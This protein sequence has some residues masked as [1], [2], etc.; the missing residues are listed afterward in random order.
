MKAATARRPREGPEKP[1]RAGVMLSAWT[2]PD[3]IRPD[4][5]RE[6]RRV[7]GYRTYCPLRRMRA[8]ANSGITDKHVMAADRLREA[9][10]LASMGY[11]A[12]RPMLFVSLPPQPR[13]GMSGADMA[14]NAA[15]RDVA[16]ALRP[17]TAGQ[18]LLL[19]A[20]VL[21][22][23]SLHAWCRRMSEQTDRRY[24]AAVEKGRLL[25][26]LDVLGQY[27]DTE[28]R[29]DLDHGRRLT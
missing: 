29:D 15:R 13:A 2:D 1:D 22:N 16:R 5:R 12:E 11:T 27:Y 26:I 28:I 24:D 21:G 7:T 20:I 25:A 17:F 10:D 14:R 8:G 18:W 6:P 3:D 23:E 19:T 9:V 4:A